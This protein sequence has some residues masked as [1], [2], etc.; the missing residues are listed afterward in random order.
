MPTLRWGGG[1]WGA[2]GER[3]GVLCMLPCAGAVQ[4]CESELV[5][6]KLSQSPN[7][8]L[9]VAQKTTLA[10]SPCRPVPEDQVRGAP[11]AV[12]SDHKSF[13]QPPGRAL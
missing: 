11:G 12:L 9:V 2:G 1:K 13:A 10:R 6:W 3:L 5:S 8:I 4:D 7:T